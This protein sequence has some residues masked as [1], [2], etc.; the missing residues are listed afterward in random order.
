MKH[1]ALALLV[2]LFAQAQSTTTPA[3]PQPDATPNLYRSGT[4]IAS[5]LQGWAACIE[6]AKADARARN[7]YTATY[8]CDTSGTSF[9]VVKDV[10]S[11]PPPPPP[12]PPPK[13]APNAA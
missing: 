5:N 10:V 2:P 1:T 11:P 4:L 7:S 6:A 12:P 8:R 13:R 9:K 3:N